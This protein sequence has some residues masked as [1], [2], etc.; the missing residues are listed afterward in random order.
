LNGATARL[1]LPEPIDVLASQEAVLK[2]W[3]LRLLRLSTFLVFAALSVVTPAT[4]HAANP[5]AQVADSQTSFKTVV[6]IPVGV[7]LKMK[8][9]QWLES[10]WATISNQVHVDKV[11]IETYRSR[12]L[13][14]DQTIEDVKKFFR[15]HG[16][17]IAGGICLSDVDHGQFV[18]FVYTKPDDRD[19]VKHVSELAAKHF[20][21]II[22]DDFFF[23]NTKTA[24]DIAAKGEQSWTDFRLKTMDEVSR[25]LVVG[26]ARAV[27]PKVKM[28]V[29]FPNWYEH[30]QGN[31][32]DLDQ[33]PK[34]FD[35]IYAGTETRDPV[36]TDQSLQ[37]YEGYNIVRYF[38]NIAP[39]RMGGGWVDTFSIHY[40][41]RYSEQLWLT[42]FA[43]AK[44]MTLFSYTDLLREP[45][46][47]E[48]PW[49]TAPTNVDWERIVKRGQGKPT[50][51]SVA[52]DALDQVKPFIDRLGKPIGIASYRPAHAVGEDFLHNFF[53]MIGIPIELYPEFSKDAPIILLTEAAKFDPNIVGEMKTQLEA[54]KTVVITSGLLRALEG[55]GGGKGGVNSIEEIVELRTTGMQEPITSFLGA[56]GPGS[57]S[58]FGAA[59]NP[60]LFPQI[61]FL[62][63][64]AWPVI[65]GI[66][67]NNA[68]PI[69]LMDHYGKGRLLVL[70]IPGNF[71]DLYEVP[72]P[73]L[74]AI[75]SYLM[76]DFP[77][78]IEAPA[79]VSLFAYDNGS[80]IVESFRD[81]PAEVMIV[82]PP[83]TTVTNLV[84]GA[85]LAELPQPKLHEWQRSY[86]PPTSKYRIEVQPHSYLVF[87]TGK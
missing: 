64:D 17:E 66:A 46:P 58:G 71:T 40:A 83:G 28:I 60:I 52:G 20:D 53:G 54:G 43:K 3:L 8:D 49:Q 87:T 85:R 86:T 14:D 15:D 79:K 6:Y 18:S 41:D 24:S 16:V 34:I 37:Q 84:T 51:A 2:A 9:R 69:L 57:G 72:E 73:A 4:A 1:T 55:K 68:F 63:N 5:A 7:T 11:Y 12:E 30:F 23:A 70:A 42:V 65:R 81:Q 38:E 80:F 76:G 33:E 32:Y 21:E 39:G 44:E 35:A 61:R 82:V 62:T 31:G 10:S 13:A 50:Y 47:G 59:A 67:N 19:Y 48:R 45:K 26:A 78:R 27:N 29:K 56:Y 74:N 77:V 75:R 22:L 36:D 25:D